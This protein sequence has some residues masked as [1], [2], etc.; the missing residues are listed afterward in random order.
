L[1]GDDSP[2]RHPGL[3]NRPNQPIRPRDLRSASFSTRFRGYDPV[4]VD[5]WMAAAADAWEALAQVAGEELL[6]AADE[7]IRPAG[8][9]DEE[10]R[11][12][13]VTPLERTTEPGD[14]VSGE[15][16]ED[17]GSDPARIL[18]R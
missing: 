8:A 5:R 10:R 18:D 4:E 14:A 12:D 2:L 15:E 6:L 7:Q 3:R 17:G 16:L 9:P 1:F 13:G 11:R